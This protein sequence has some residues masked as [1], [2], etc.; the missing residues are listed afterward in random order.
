MMAALFVCA[1]ATYFF[2]R[3]VSLL[4]LPL[5]ALAIAEALFDRPGN[6]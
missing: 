5:G 4:M 2:L 3:P 6:D 1:I